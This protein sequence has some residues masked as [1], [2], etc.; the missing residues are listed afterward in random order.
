MEKERTES[1][2][3]TVARPRRQAEHSITYKQI[4]KDLNTYIHTDRNIHTIPK[5]SE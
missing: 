5:D 3:E 4:D 2:I 1:A